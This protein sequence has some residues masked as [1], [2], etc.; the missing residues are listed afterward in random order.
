MGENM[1]TEGELK[2]NNFQNSAQQ[3]LLLKNPEN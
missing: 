3:H 1:G 2:K